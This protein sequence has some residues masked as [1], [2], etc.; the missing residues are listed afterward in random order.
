[1][2]LASPFV[3]GLQAMLAAEQLGIPTV[4]VYQT[5]VPAY[6]TRYGFP[7]AEPLLWQQVQ[8]IH[9]RATLNLAPSSYAAGSWPITASTGS[10]SGYAGRHRALLSGQA[11]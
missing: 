4:A 6:A 8:R 11:R 1:V 5:D 2:H 7:L 10:E 9:Q 3:L